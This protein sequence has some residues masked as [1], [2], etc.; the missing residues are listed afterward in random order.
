[1]ELGQLFTAFLS[2]IFV[3]G[4]L[5][6]TLWAIKLL[7]TKSCCLSLCGKTKKSRS[8][9]IIEQRRLDAKNQLVLFEADNIRYLVLLGNEAPLLLKQTP[10]K[11]SSHD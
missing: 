3:L 8:I 2:L 10:L 4:L 9:N 1:M 5:L 7:Q 6:L 11:G